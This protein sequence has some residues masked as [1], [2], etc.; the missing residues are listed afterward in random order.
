MNEKELRKQLIDTLRALAQWQDAY[1][2][3]YQ[4]ELDAYIAV[5]G[6]EPK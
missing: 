1:E 3:M 4:L 2:I 6:E 5:Y